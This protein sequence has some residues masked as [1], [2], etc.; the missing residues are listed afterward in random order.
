MT[1]DVVQVRTK[2]FRGMPFSFAEVRG[3]PADHASWWSFDD[4]QELRDRWWTPRAGDTV[5]DIGAA[6]GSWAL[7]ALAL[8]ARVIA[9]SPAEFDT[10]LL[11]ENLRHNPDFA[12]R[13]MVTRDGLYS[14]DGW[15]DPDHC[16]FSPSPVQ[17]GQWLRVRA[18]DAFMAERPGI[19]KIDWMKLDVEG[20]EL[21]VLKGAERSIRMYAPKIVVEN[22]EFQ[23]R[24]IENQVKDFLFGLGL[25]YTCDGPYQHCAVSHSFFTPGA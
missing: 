8:G 15:F 5:F 2:T 22:H 25:G 18:L 20:A 19:E 21:E 4:E 3:T 9:F 11:E 1:L 6:F 14:Q 17:E 13:C 16:K 24:G 7:P 10:E 12:R 23:C